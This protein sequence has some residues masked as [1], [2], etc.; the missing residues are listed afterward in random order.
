[1]SCDLVVISKDMSL[2]AAARHLS[3][4]R[5]SGAPIVD[6]DGRC[7][8]VVSASD[9]MRWADKRGPQAPAY[10]SA[11]DCYCA[12]WQVFDEV[13]GSLPE[14]RVSAYMT[15]DPV[16][17]PLHTP[18]R[19]LAQRMLDAHIHRIIIVNEERRPIGIVSSTDILA[20]VAGAADAGPNRP[21]EDYGAP[22]SQ[23]P[24]KIAGS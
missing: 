9:F 12:A 17:V 24:A 8:G 23:A 15:A 3:G 19:A 13:E 22:H 5:I 10:R 14:E 16:T 7:I 1:M 20:A 18:I 6:A 21:G 2:R 11:S 4:N